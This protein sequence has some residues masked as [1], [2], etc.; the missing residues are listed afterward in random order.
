MQPINTILKK[1]LAARERGN[2]ETATLQE[3][4]VHAADSPSA[5]Q[6]AAKKGHLRISR[7]KNGT[8]TLAANPTLY[9]P[10]IHF[11]GAELKIFLAKHTNKAI[12]TI[13]FIPERA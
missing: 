7:F 10:E 9:S 1:V 11:L 5:A 2:E 4:L 8:V 3:L 13:R 6:E 12:R